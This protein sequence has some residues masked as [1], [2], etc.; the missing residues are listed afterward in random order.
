MACIRRRQ[1]HRGRAGKPP[2]DPLPDF[3]ANWSTPIRLAAS[4]LWLELRQQI[5]ELVFLSGW[6]D[7][8]R[9]ASDL[10]LDRRP[11][12]ELQVRCNASGQAKR[13]A[14]APLRNCGLHRS[15]LP[16]DLE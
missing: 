10:Q 1:N 5:I 16:V 11:F 13:K 12:N 4:M 2:R 9:L 7:D 14:V 3:F 15:V 8:D 6:G